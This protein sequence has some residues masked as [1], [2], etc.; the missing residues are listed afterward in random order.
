MVIGYK[1]DGSKIYRYKTIQAKGP[2]EAKKQLT[3]F[4]AEI[5]NGQYINIEE[6]MT[7]HSFYKEWLEKHANDSLSPDTKQ[8][9]YKHLKQAYT[10]KLRSYEAR[11]IKDH[12]CCKLYEGFKE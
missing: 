10:P 6:K 8:Y 11:G 12:S 9:Y 5:L 3:M 2:K 7:L 4:E 1:E